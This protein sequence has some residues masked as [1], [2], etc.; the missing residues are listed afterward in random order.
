MKLLK[1]VNTRRLKYGS[2][3]TALT[4]SFIAV[5]LIINLVCTYLTTN[6]SLKLDISGDGLFEL[7]EETKQY[8]DKMDKE[9]E[10]KVYSSEAEFPTELKE[11]VRRIVLENDK[12]SLEFIDPDLNPTFPTSFPQHDI[13]EGCLVMKSGSQVRV[14]QGTEMGTVDENTL[15]VTYL[16]EERVASALLHFLENRD[17]K[18]YFVVGHGE[19]TDPTFRRLF[20]DNG[21]TVEDIYLSDDT[22]F[23][24]NATTMVV[25]APQQ[26]FSD[27]Q[28]KL[29]ENFLVNNQRYGKNLMFF[30]SA[31]AQATPYL[32]D[33]LY[34]WGIVVEKDMVIEGDATAVGGSAINVLPSLAENDLTKAMGGYNGGCIM[35]GTASLTARFETSNE[36]TLFPLLT[37]SEQSYAKDSTKGS[38]ATYD[39]LEGD[40]EGPFNVAMISRLQKADNNQPVYSHVFVAG[41]AG[42]LSQEVI[43]S[44]GNGNFLLSTYNLMMQREGQ[45]IL[46]AMKSSSTKTTVVT[47]SNLDTM[48]VVVMGVIPGIV[49]LIGVFVFIRRR[50]L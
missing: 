49:L 25:V 36:K 21:Y 28:V 17:E 19:S 46:N 45:T 38:I 29:V 4:V 48:N 5:V 43:A 30:P 2:L 26:D 9:V 22:E 27:K 15:G 41:N 3:A 1:N 50:Y 37:T 42:M 14:I 39:K 20:A 32:D 12:F 40:K 6:Y 10:F 11:I 7:A 16:L 13:S 8:I 18:I 33:L 24:A 44:S 35:L 34:D 31:T 23:D 47:Q